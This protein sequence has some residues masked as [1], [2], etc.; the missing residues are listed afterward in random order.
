MNKLD[1]IYDKWVAGLKYLRCPLLL[2]MRLYWGYQFFI[3]G[4]GKLMN[5]DRTAGFFSELHIPFPKLNAGVAGTIE[6][7]GGLL[8]LLGLGSRIITV[9]MIFTML[10]AYSTAH[11]DVLREIFKNP[12]GVVSAPPFLFLLTCVIVLVFGPGKISLDYLIARM[13][14]RHT[15]P[16]MLS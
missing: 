1:R 4:K 3:T 16:R 11:R 5:L 8:L 15:E 2:A 10:V 13:R 7:F 14:G 6:C 12:D 9:P